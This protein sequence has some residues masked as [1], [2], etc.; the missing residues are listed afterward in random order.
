MKPYFLSNLENL[1]EAEG[2]YL[3]KWEILKTSTLGCVFRGRMR[4]PC[5]CP[6]DF[7]YRDDEDLT[8]ANVIRKI[9]EYIR[10]H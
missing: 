9:K 3:H 10:E 5:R 2:W 6:L 8:A 1:A 4:F 7:G